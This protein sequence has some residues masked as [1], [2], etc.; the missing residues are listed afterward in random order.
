MLVLELFNSI[1]FFISFHTEQYN[2]ILISKLSMSSI[3]CTLNIVFIL[4]FMIAFLAICMSCGY[5]EGISSLPCSTLKMCQC[6]VLY[7]I[8]IYCTRNIRDSVIRV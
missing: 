8:I 1:Q 7:S 2:F 5:R 4:I 6:S 3:N